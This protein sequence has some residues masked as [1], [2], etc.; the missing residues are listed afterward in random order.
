M[1]LRARAE[2]RISRVA[3]TETSSRSAEALL[4][5][6]QVHQI[7][8]EMQNETLRRAQIDL[9]TSRDRYVEL[10][11]FAPVGYFTLTSSGLIVA[12]NLT[13]AALL[14][15]VRTKLYNRRFSRFIVPANSD[16]WHNYFLHVQRHSG[17]QSCNLA[18]QRSDGSVFYAH[19]DSLCAKDPDD[20]PAVRVALT[21][22]TAETEL[23]STL[24]NAEIKFQLLQQ[25]RLL[26]GSMYA[27]QENERRHIAREL[28]DELGQWLTAIQAEAEAIC[29]SREIAR[30]PGILASARAIIECAAE[31]HEMIH[32][33]MRR[34]RPSL[35]D[36]LGLADSLQELVAEWRARYPQVHC[37][38]ALNGDL[39][40][41][42]DPLDITVYRVVQE[43]LTNIAKHAQ[44][45]RV[46]LRLQRIRDAAAADTLLL[47]VSDDGKGMVPE[48]STRGLGL[49]GMRERVI[50]LDGEFMLNCAPGQ[51]VRIEVRLPL[52]NQ[53]RHQEE[54]HVFEP[55]L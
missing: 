27:L 42:G 29:S 19:L 48:T 7:E 25:N 52:V 33:M 39:G 5:E 1:K 15:E 34:L 38:L 35:L 22:I 54:Q 51:G 50:A 2:A 16:R 45:S 55:H 40:G 10:F 6:L 11:E 32:K 28:H 21:D 43:A 47:S 37:D 13:G 18:L 26:T 31:E 49:L 44:A 3:G 46:S 53:L 12:A 14:G 23:Q 30:C 8:L 41:V 24:Q 4:H 9:E 17:R 20:H 36:A